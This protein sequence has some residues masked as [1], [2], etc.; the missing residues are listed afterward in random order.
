MFAQ[1]VYIL[2]IRYQSGIEIS[3]DLRKINYQKTFS[4]SL[5][6]KNEVSKYI[7]TLY[8]RAYITAFCQLQKHDSSLF[9][10]TVNPGLKYKWIKL[11]KGNLDKSFMS[12]SGFNEK[13][14]TEKP[15][16]YKDIYRLCERLLLYCENNG[17]PFAALCLDSIKINNNEIFG[18]INLTKNQEFRIDSIVVKGNA[19][20]VPVYLY[21]YL[22]MKRNGLYNETSVK[23]IKNRINELPF[24]SETH[25]YELS[26]SGSSAKIFLYLN[27][28]KASQFEGILGIMPNPAKQGKIDVTGEAKLRLQNAFNRGELVDLNW[29]KNAGNTQDLKVNLAYPLLFSTPFGVDGKFSLFKKDTTYLSLNE[30]FGI[31]YIFSGNSYFK[32]FVDNKKSDLLTTKG[33]E[34]LTVIPSYADVSSLLYGLEYKLEKLDYRLNPSKGVAFRISGSAG[35][36][37]IRKNDKINPALYDSLKLTSAQFSASSDWAVFIPIIKR[38]TFKIGM[39]A[40]WIDNSTLFENELY[41]I[42]GLKTFRGFDEESIYTSLYSI[43]TLEFRYLLEQNSYTYLFFDGAYFENKSIHKNYSDFPYGFGAGISMETK[44][45]IFSV[46]YALGKQKNT[47]LDLRSSKIHFGIT[48]YF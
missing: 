12:I 7:T 5:K 14:F 44:L 26:F 31:N 32:V 18:S 13:D 4:D 41:R 2:E 8:D 22:N 48:N 34:N 46:C 33:L 47:S 10:A 28:K 16:Y 30:N 1:K 27:A 6:L 19:K 39:N 37:K 23:K 35:T 21:T 15:F 11:G 40:A 36:K 17:Y 25:P 24:V 43:G 29:K 38:M 3:K 42:G 9:I 20:I 45:G